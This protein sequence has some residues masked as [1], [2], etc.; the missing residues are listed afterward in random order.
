[1][2]DKDSTIMI[3]DDMRVMRKSIMMFLKTLGYSNFI[4][5]ENGADA[6]SK[7][8]SN[9]IDFVFMDLVMPIQ[10]GYQALKAI[11]QNDDA[12]TVVMLTSIADQHILDKCLNKGAFGYI[13]KPLTPDTAE[14]KLLSVLSKVA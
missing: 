8:Q 13:H 9:E 6:V 2:L 1:M 3:V 11:K 4:E 5:A 14:E 7:Y 10:D 12:A